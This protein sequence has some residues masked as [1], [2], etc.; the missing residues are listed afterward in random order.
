MEQRIGPVSSPSLALKALSIGV[1]LC[2]KLCGAV[3]L[4]DSNG[5]EKQRNSIR[6]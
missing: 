6:L 5:I 3:P 4:Y 1:N 2:A